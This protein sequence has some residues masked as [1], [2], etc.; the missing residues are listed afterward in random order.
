MSQ[1]AVPYMGDLVV[2]LRTL[3]AELTLPE[4]VARLRDA[5]QVGERLLD[6]NT[7]W[8]QWRKRD[9]TRGLRR[10]ADDAAKLA[11]DLES[12]S[13]RPTRAPA[14]ATAAPRS[15]PRS[16]APSP[17]STSRLPASTGVEETA[18][19]PGPRPATMPGECPGS[20]RRRRVGS[21]RWLVLGTSV[22]VG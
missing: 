20:S 6:Q 7:A 12:P 10:A 3:P 16:S 8:W 18:G 9:D 22:Y 1:V 4:M 15:T 11:D 17:R 21:S 2:L 5:A 13:R 19:R 14:P